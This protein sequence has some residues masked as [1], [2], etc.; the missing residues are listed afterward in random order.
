MR[1]PGF[2]PH[3]PP[4]ESH[5]GGEGPLGIKVRV[6]D[7]GHGGSGLRETARREVSLDFYE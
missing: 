2:C 7:L 6:R 3:P 1:V 5:T 4:R